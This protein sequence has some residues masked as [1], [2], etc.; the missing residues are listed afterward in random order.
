LTG[1]E[2]GQPDEKGKFPKDSVN[3][4]VNTR[5]EQMAHLR[6]EFVKSSDESELDDKL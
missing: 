4:R 2:A 6:H 1:I 5:L 3:E